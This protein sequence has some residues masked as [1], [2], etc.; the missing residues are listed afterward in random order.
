MSAADLLTPQDDPAN[1]DCLQGLVRNPVERPIL[2]NGAMIRAINADRKTQTRR[3]VKYKGKPPIGLYGKPGDRLW[4][5]ETWAPCIGG[6]CEPGNP[7][8]YRA[9]RK[10]EYENLTWRPSIFMPR[11]A[12][13]ITLQILAVRVDR[14]Q[15]MARTEARDEGCGTEDVPWRATGRTGHGWTDTYAEL[16]D[17]INLKRGHGWDSNPWVWVI[18]FAR[19][20]NAEL[21]RESANRQQ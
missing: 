6:P 5:R 12:S 16:W 3:V 14:L 21:C 20:S 7:V 4:V 2:F 13:R 10:P 15:S 1:G 19:I 9:D 8:L 18:D 11:W 17:S